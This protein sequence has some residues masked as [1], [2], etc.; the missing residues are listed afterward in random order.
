MT[1]DLGP[2][3]RAQREDR[4]WSRNEMARR[5]TAAA[6]ETGDTA[7]PDAETIRGYIYRWEH[8]KTQA[9]SER[10]VLHYCRA[11]GI[12]PAQFAGQPEPASDIAA[13]QPTAVLTPEAVVSS[14]QH[15]A[16]RG[17]EAPNIGQSTV[18]HEIL[19]AAH[20]GSEHAE[21]AEQRDFGDITLEQLHADVV[22]LSAGLM[23]GDPFSQFLE[24]RRVRD[25][26]YR[27][28]EGHL[29]PGDQADLYFLLGCL[30][31]LM[32]ASASELGYGQAAE[33]LIRAG[34]AYASAIDNRPLMAHLRLQLASI[35]LWY[36]QPR[37]AR[38]LAED[39]LRYLT[40]GPTGATLYLKY[41]QAAAR[42]GDA[43]GVRRALAAASDAHH[44]KH[45]DDVAAIGGE[46]GLSAATEHYFAGSALVL[47]DDAG[48]EAA[49]RLEQALSLYEAGPGPG[50]QHWFGA[51]A[52]TSIDLATVRLRSGALDAAVT[53]ISPALSLPSARRVKALMTRLQLVRTE[54][55]APVFRGSAQARDLDERIEEFG[56]DSVTAGL[57]ALP[58]GPA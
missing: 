46:F 55:A 4:G 45:D 5:L 12:K 17:I 42:T 19:M 16:Y 40:A 18:R 52:M 37:R 36:G 25:R 23:T 27:L 29:R 11:L 41:A 3:L 32:A 56:R 10:Y 58:S 35:V 13:L 51:K 54:L 24:M 9:L 31:D 50:E 33:E 39:G 7:L 26:V 8:G 47:V 28:L 49:D 57:H 2:W 38:E 30:S 1:T 43:D 53:A 20:E 15:V 48:N 21:Q 22:R 44:G 34:W 6:R 14:C